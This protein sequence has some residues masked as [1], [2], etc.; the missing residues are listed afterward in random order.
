MDGPATE[1][2]RSPNSVLVRTM[3]AAALVVEDCSQILL[4]SAVTN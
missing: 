1:K 3:V 2:A 4:E